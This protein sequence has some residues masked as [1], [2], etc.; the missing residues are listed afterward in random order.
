MADL[1]DL[2][3]LIADFGESGASL[4]PEVPD[5]QA[6]QP[7]MTPSKEEFEE[8]RGLLDTITAPLDY[9]GNISRSAI[10]AGIRK[11]DPIKAAQEAAAFDRKTTPNELKKAL[12]IKTFGID[13]GKFQ[14]ADILDVGL[15][16]VI[17]G[18]TDPLTYE[19]MGFSAL[20]KPLK[21]A[22]KAVK[23]L[24]GTEAIEAASK[25]K[26]FSKQMKKIDGLELAGRVGADN[27]NRTDDAFRLL[28][29]ELNVADYGA[30]VAKKLDL[31]LPLS[32]D[33]AKLMKNMPDTIADAAKYLR[34]KSIIQ[35]FLGAAYGLGTA[36]KDSSLE[37]LATRAGIGALTGYVGPKA[38]GPI[39][40]IVGKEAAAAVD[41]YV[42]ITR[43]DIIKDL[44]GKYNDLAR[45]QISKE[46]G[47]SL[48][49]L[50]KSAKKQFQSQV[51]EAA[52]NGE[53]LPKGTYE[54]IL[55]GLK[56]SHRD[57]LLDEYQRLNPLPSFAKAWVTSLEAYDKINAA[58]H[59]LK[60]RRWQ[61]LDG[62]NRKEIREV[63]DYMANFKNI[64]TAERNVLL[65]KFSSVAE[66]GKRTLR[67]G[68]TDDQIVKGMGFEKSILKDNQIV[69]T[70]GM[71]LLHQLS[72]LRANE[73][74]DTTIYRATLDKLYKQ[75]MKV[76]G[77]IESFVKNNEDFVKMYNKERGT[78]LI[79]I[80]WHIDD[81][82]TPKDLEEASEMIR[83]QT[84]NV[85]KTK[86]MP[87]STEG[88]ALLG[89]DL[90]YAV[91]AQQ[92]GR[93]LISTAE[94]DAVK[95]VQ[96]ILKEPAQ[97]ASAR[98]L[99]GYLKVWDK[100]TN[101][102]KMNM[103]LGNVTWHKNNYF[104]NITKA[105]MEGGLSPA[106]QVLFMGKLKK[107]GGDI[108]RLSNNETN[109]KGMI[110]K[111]KDLI[112]MLRLGVF[113]GQHFDIFHKGIDK[114]VGDFLMP[115]KQFREKLHK[116]AE[117]S[118]VGKIADTWMNGLTATS[119][120]VGSYL[121]GV[122]RAITYKHHVKEF[123][124]S[125]L[126]DTMLKD[127]YGVVDNIKKLKRFKDTP[128]DV[129]RKQAKETVEERIKRMSAGVV[130][131]TYFDY[132]KATYFENAVMKRIVPFYTFYSRNVPYWMS[133][134][135]DPGKVG[136]L[137]IIDSLRSNIGTELSSYERQGLSD[138]MKD[139]GPRKVGSDA[140]GLR[141]A[142]NPYT[143]WYDAIRVLNPKGWGSYVMDK[144]H[145]VPKI[146][147]ESL[148]K[149][150]YFTGG[151]NLPSQARN[152][153]EKRA[154]VE[155]QK[156]MFSK[157]YKYWFLQQAMKKKYPG[158]DLGIRR[159]LDGDVYAISNE[160]GG[161]GD[162]LVYFDKMI[163]TLF[164]H[165]GVEKIVGALGDA[166]SG[167]KTWTDSFMNT[168]SP[169]QVMSVDPAKFARTYKRYLT[170]KGD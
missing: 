144:M 100:W 148:L 93:K 147:L 133:A 83:L 125:P 49:G 118:G 18:L 110:G 28:Q 97:F 108:W 169:W 153:L 47:K 74:V 165:G 138:Y 159:D 112:D 166:D 101:W 23:G 154:G 95:Y 124:D 3:K 127:A 2:D 73:I 62:L 105:Y 149:K 88:R 126:Y 35:P 17:D 94:N 66:S 72:T 106:I 56:N 48:N 14:L 170:K 135:F 114:Q 163:N 11:E 151:P 27:L 115:V 61:A 92:A 59:W 150:D 43:P 122:G 161:K 31:D 168:I 120:R 16:M 142:I 143:S 5:Q 89:E 6:T 132:K 116:Q 117:Q 7:S 113:E 98:K 76:A 24:A 131:Q 71:D 34:Y 65:D 32:D 167:K 156:P 87:S 70:Q 41:K 160:P 15:D 91:Y 51:K 33:A 136:R 109:I 82:F 141:V 64:F 79:G 84:S 9:Q 157:S 68:V 152:L 8:D 164:P 104:D 90:S 128:I 85:F 129:L 12:G 1:F 53:K 29:G 25:V 36:N 60:Q 50:K 26:N 22:H 96:A 75:N 78:N 10:I 162:K 38:F 140:R 58:A 42:E 13:D 40:Q 103:L 4:Q 99:E 44:K 69:G 119:G 86:R 63:T 54:K 123:M 45:N 146:A 39:K 121:E 19:T 81:V 57:S 130:K 102:I 139:A 55:D 52:L 145:P 20:L 21:H 107:L 77:G 158:V 137:A 30:Y 67:K 134:S 46:I 111:D 37:D 155:G 80:K